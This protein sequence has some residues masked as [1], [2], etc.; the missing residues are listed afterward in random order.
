MATVENDSKVNQENEEQIVQSQETT[1]TSQPSSPKDSVVEPVR[2]E[3]SKAETSPPVTSAPA[4]EPD[5][6]VTE[7]SANSKLEESEEKL[8]ETATNPTP[9]APESQPEQ[10][11]TNSTTSPA[12]LLHHVRTITSTSNYHHQEAENSEATTATSTGQQFTNQENQMVENVNNSSTA[13]Y[14]EGTPL[15]EQPQE[16][17]YYQDQ[18]HYTDDNGVPVRYRDIPPHKSNVQQVELIDAAAQ[19]AGVPTSY[20]IMQGDEDDQDDRTSAFLGSRLA[21]FQV[22][23]S[24]FKTPSFCCPSWFVC[25]TA[26][27]ARLGKMIDP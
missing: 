10:E 19:A 22:I 7:N 20:I 9:S 27:L 24:T 23:Y 5:S 18:H 1:K 26:T 25:C 4:N 15:E 11:S 14:V 2:E 17:A 16:G 8:Q 6:T 12:P 21:T 3:E 13:L